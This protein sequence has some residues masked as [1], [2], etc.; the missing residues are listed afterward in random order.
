MTMS[1]RMSKSKMDFEEMLDNL[2]FDFGIS[3]YSFT[4][5]EIQYLAEKLQAIHKAMIAQNQDCLPNLLDE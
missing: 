3:L 1:K 4:Q 2:D 5:G